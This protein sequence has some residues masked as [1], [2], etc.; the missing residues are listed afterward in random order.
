MVA[1]LLVAC[2]ER[3]PVDP[4][5]ARIDA[6]AARLA[7]AA[8]YAE[9]SGAPPEVPLA[10]A[11]GAAPLEGAP[12]LLVVGEGEV[13]L[14][15]RGV[16]A[17]DDA[18]VAERLAADLRALRDVSVREG[19][20]A[21]TVALWVDPSVRVERLAALLAPASAHARFALLVRASDVRVPR[22]EGA[23]EWVAPALR[24]RASESAYDRRERIDR[25]WERATGRCEA[26]RGHLP[27]PAAL[28][29]SGPPMGAPSVEPLVRAMRR[30][31]CEQSD[32]AAMEAV[33]RAA[34]V[35]P[36]GP[37][38]RVPAALRFGY[39]TD[40]ARE[41]VVDAQDTVAELAATLAR[42]SGDESIW[43]VAK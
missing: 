2:S 17:G 7:R 41:L 36:E 15:G 21:W 25:A 35:S 27:I 37:L 34:L 13:R 12:P 43:I 20:E 26:A 30:C 1:L 42:S 19:D 28:A 8:R 5:A 3:A 18:R 29:P 33:A 24:A 38:A 4:C 16:G 22:A 11:R 10:Q 40:D 39:A 31:G 32:L 6:I 23:P 9:P 14:A